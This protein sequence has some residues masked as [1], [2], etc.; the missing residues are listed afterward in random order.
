MVSPYMELALIPFE[1]G[2]EL[3]VSH[4]LY[5]E[6]VS[7]SGFRLSWIC[8]NHVPLYGILPSRG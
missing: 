8:N 7:V 3:L 1:I 2:L 4:I 5:L 6:S